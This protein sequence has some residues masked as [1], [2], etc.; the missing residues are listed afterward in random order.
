MSDTQQGQD[1]WKA[2]DGKWYPPN[3]PLDRGA[4]PQAKKGG[5]LKAAL[6][7][8]AVL[9]LLGILGVVAG[10]M[11]VNEAA[12]EDKDELEGESGTPERSL[13]PDRSDRQKEDQEV[14]VGGE[15]RLSGYTASVAS[16]EFRPQLDQFR[17]DGYLVVSVTVAN[18][19][20][21][22]QMYNTFDWKL[23]T[24][25]GQVIDP[26]FSGDQTV[27]S[28]DLVPGG[29]TQGEVTFEIGATK[30]DYYV[31]YKPDPFDAA[32]GVWKVTV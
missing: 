27:G 29:T 21:E 25:N 22:T 10:G 20:D 7:A 30:G 13:Y 28:G 26:T 8:F 17:T 11:L 24:P 18:R 31:I 4:Q 3:A 2:S 1:W 14:Q 23:Q 15:V 5:C 32:R 9:V 19:D 6:I 12:D 16:A